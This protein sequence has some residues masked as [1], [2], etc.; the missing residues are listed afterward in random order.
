MAAPTHWLTFHG[1]LSRL[2]CWGFFLV[3]VIWRKRIG[4]RVSPRLR[5]PLIPGDSALCLI[6][7]RLLSSMP[8]PFPVC[9]TWPLR[10]TFPGGSVPN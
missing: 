1:P 4:G 3:R 10:V 5:M 7:A 6:S 9:G 8:W 2:R